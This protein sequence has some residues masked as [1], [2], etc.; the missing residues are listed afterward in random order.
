MNLPIDDVRGRV[1]DRKLDI[2]DATIASALAAI[3][4]G[5]HVALIGN[6]A[7]PEMV[8]AFAELLADCAAAL[9]FCIAW[10]NLPATSG[11]LVRLSDLVKRRFLTDLW[12]VLTNPSPTAIARVIDDVR[13]SWTDS[14]AR[15]IVATSR[16]S[17]R[18]AN[19]SPAQRRTLIPI[20]A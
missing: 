2:P 1:S 17:L 18:Q 20:V 11:A 13:D 3:T 10:L 5:K 8:A 14:N 4:T 6:E 19:L 16:E 7:S 9:D 15:L 12:L